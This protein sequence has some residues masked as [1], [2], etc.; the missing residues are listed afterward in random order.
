MFSL[1]LEK[2]GPVTSLPYCFV[3]GLPAARFFLHQQRHL[4][5]IPHPSVARGCPAAL[6]PGRRD[7][8]VPSTSSHILTFCLTSCEILSKPSVFISSIDAWETKERSSLKWLR[9]PRPA[10]SGRL[11]KADGSGYSQPIIRK[12]SP[13]WSSPMSP[14]PSELGEACMRGE[15]NY[16]SQRGGGHQEGMA[17]SIT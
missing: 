5:S 17:L 10:P 2:P 14:S 12:E 7:R 16:G 1:T 11:R 13:A 9:P 6:H 4:A 3:S 8:L 15:G